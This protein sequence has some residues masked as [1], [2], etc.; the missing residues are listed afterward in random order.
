M[1]PRKFGPQQRQARHSKLLRAK[2][3]A[4][5]NNQVVNTCPF[6]CRDHQIDQNGYCYHLIGTSDDKRTYEPMVLKNGARWTDGRKREKIQD[7]D[8]VV[9][10]SNNFRVY[11]D[12]EM[13]EG[14]R[15]YIESA[16]NAADVPDRDE[17]DEFVF[18]S[19]KKS[20]KQPVVEEPEPEDE[21]VEITTDDE[22]EVVATGN[23]EGEATPLK[24]R[25]NPVE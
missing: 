1:D 8:H 15:E 17:G 4:T 10:I 12:I 14:E 11:R 5:A 25:G 6:G 24:Y 19:P 16:G 7:G 2:K 20:K 22:E 18:R 3:K 13:P 21:E 23:G 9:R